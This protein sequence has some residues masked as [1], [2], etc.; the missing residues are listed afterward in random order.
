MIKRLCVAAMLA[1]LACSCATAPTPRIA[2][3]CEARLLN[4]HGEFA[5]E[6]SS[7][8]WR[9]DMGDG[10]SAHLGQP[11]AWQS[12]DSILAN[13]FQPSERLDAPLLL[14]A[15]NPRFNRNDWSAEPPALSV[16]GE[17]RIGARSIRD[18]ANDHTNIIFYYSQ[19]R[20][21]LGESGDMEALLFE[22]PSR[23]PL[24][25]GAIPRAT[26]ESVEPTIQALIR[27]LREMQA[28]PQAHCTPYEEDD[29]IVL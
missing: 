16:A 11:D 15:F 2:Y 12:Y 1:L 4:E 14:V 19:W 18:W 20:D 9:Y 8:S 27:Q 10:M 29:I 25:H 28:N 24:Q 3:A 5:L 26:L 22:S 21:L 13:G 6:P 17:L 23:A 7:W